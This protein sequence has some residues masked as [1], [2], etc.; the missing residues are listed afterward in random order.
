M[1]VTE[2]EGAGV[3]DAR[4]GRNVARSK[5]DEMGQ[6]DHRNKG[7]VKA[8]GQK[9][10]KPVYMR[11][12]AGYMQWSENPKTPCARIVAV[13]MVPESASPRWY[14]E[15]FGSSFLNV[16]YIEINSDEAQKMK[17]EFRGEF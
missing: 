15:K 8:F 14:W 2:L 11:M 3:A 4:R 5:K 12:T 17:K 9:H 1:R 10:T 16:A 13:M 7:K 6:L